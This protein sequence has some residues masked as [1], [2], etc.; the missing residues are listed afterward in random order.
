MPGWKPHIAAWARSYPTGAEALSIGPPSASGRKMRDISF[1]RHQQLA[2]NKLHDGRVGWQVGFSRSIRR[3]PRFCAPPLPPE[4][5]AE[6]GLQLISRS[7]AMPE[8]GQAAERD[9]LPVQR[10]PARAAAA[11]PSARSSAKRGSSPGA[12]V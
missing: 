11:Q 9:P 6:L 8:G 3:S 10:D 5:H 2:K 1:V 12:G 7:A 4:D